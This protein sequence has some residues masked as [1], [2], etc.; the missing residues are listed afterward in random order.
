[1]RWNDFLTAEAPTVLMAHNA[2]SDL[3][4]LDS[5]CRNMNLKWTPPPTLCTVRLA[6]LLWPDA[7]RYG[8]EALL[9][10]LDP[11][12]EEVVHHRALPDAL[13]TR[14]LFS[15][16]VAKTQPRDMA[17]V[18]WERA[19]VP[20]ENREVPVDA[21]PRLAALAEA[22]RDGRQVRLI[23]RGG[24]K[25]R[26]RR[27]ITP[28]GFFQQGDLVYLRGWCHLDDLAKVFRCDK[29]RGLASC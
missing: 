16:C 15:R 19:L 25:G 27:P 2:R 3:A 1:P 21:P 26:E 20:T 9:D 14:K 12:R 8:L 23:Y 5:A 29:I 13:H 28:L 10:W 22:A 17:E 18:E 7:P 6:R 11:E 4:F 24:T